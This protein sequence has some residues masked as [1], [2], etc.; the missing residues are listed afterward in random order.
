M[1]GSFLSAGLMKEL[2]WGA[3]AVHV[4]IVLGLGVAN[5]PLLGRWR[6]GERLA[7]VPRFLRQI[8]YV[9]WAYILIVVGMFAALCFGF[10]ADLAGGSGLGRF[11]SGFMAGFWLLR[12][13][14]QVFYYDEQLRRENRGMDLLYVVSLI[15]L[16]GIFG[17]AALRP[18]G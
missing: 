11:L 12:I 6:V 14:L 1:S 2:I 5:S 13:G 17:M 8:V 15:V 3:G 16:V 7:G 9:H 4:G 10:A 18:V